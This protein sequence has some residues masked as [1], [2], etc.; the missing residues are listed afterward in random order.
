MG[1]YVPPSIRTVR[2]DVQGSAVVTGGQ[3]VPAFIGRAVGKKVPVQ[4][5]QATLGA[6]PVFPIPNLGA[7]GPALQITNVRSKPTGGIQYS[8]GSDY[9]FDPDAQTV[10]FSAQPALLQPYATGVAEAAGTSSLDPDE[11]YY[12][13]VTA[14]RANDGT[15]AGETVA[16]NI[17]S[18]KPSATNRRAVIGWNPS[19]GADGYKVYVSTNPN[20]FSGNSLVATISGPYTN[21]YTYDGTAATTG[22]P[23]GPAS[24]GRVTAATN[25]PYDGTTGDTLIAAVDGGSPV[26]ITFTGAPAQRLGTGITYPVTLTGSETMVVRVNSGT[27]HNVPALSAGTHTAADIAGAITAAVPAGEATADV[28]GGQVRIRTVQGGTGASLEVTGTLAAAAGLATGVTAGTGNVANIDA[29]TPQEVIDAINNAPLAGGTAQLDGVF[30]AIVSNTTGTT[31]SIQITGGTANTWL[32]FPTGLAS[33]AAARTANAYRRPA[34]NGGTFYFDYVY[35]AQSHFTVKRFTKL[36]LLIQ[37]YGMGSDLAIAATLAMGSSGRG[38]S[39]SIVLAMSVPDNQLSSYQTALDFLTRRKDVD[40]VVPLTHVSG[41]E[42][43]IKSHC[44]TQSSVDNKRERIALLGTDIG[45]ALGDDVTPGTAVYLAQ[46]M[47]SRRVIVTY[48][49]PVCDVQGTDGIIVERELPGWAMA[50]ALSG[51]IASQPDRATPITEKRVLGIKRLG[52]ELDESEMNIGGAAGLCIV[53]QDETGNFV[54]RDGVT[55]TLENEADQQISINLTDDF[56]CRSLRT[57]FRQFRGRKLLPTVLDQIQNKT[58]KLLNI[59]VKSALIVG[60]D[61]GSIS[62]VQDPD[63]LT[64]VIVTFKYQPIFPVRVV[65][66]RYALDL[67]AISLAA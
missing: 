57:Q 32:G 23:P 42:S 61:A 55:T 18:F 34:L 56:L 11:T 10:N 48:P 1:V 29:I 31:S 66:F 14:T 41:I 6:T 50:S 67:R 60:F 33:G 21:S 54:V 35:L 20:V 5:Y 49:W 16:S 38:N 58:Q 4:G 40:L 9:T 59:F 39:A 27:V 26:T 51:V 22:T 30:P 17:V 65:E 3:V 25:G 47:A 2:E 24:S 52:V 36:N 45:T 15:T 44:E 13:G 64:W 63:R 8:P 7:A 28:S 37:E 19:L 53:E 43:S 12:F 46:Q 62:A